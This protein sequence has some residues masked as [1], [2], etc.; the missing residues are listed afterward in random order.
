[1]VVFIILIRYHGDERMSGELS[2]RLLQ[3]TPSLYSAEDAKRAKAEESLS[4]ASDL[5]GDPTVK[6]CM[7]CPYTCI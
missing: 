1:M 4:L 7:Y 5:S 3:L 2:N 6:V